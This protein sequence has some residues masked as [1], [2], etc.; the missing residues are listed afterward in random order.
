MNWKWLRRMAWLDTR[1]AFVSS[2]RHG[3]KLLD[4]GS[5]DGETLSHIAELRPDIALCACDVKGCP[6]KYPLGCHFERKNLE[7]DI[8]PWPN[9]SIDG[10]TCMHLVEHLASLDN[11]L[12]ECA[13]LL[14]PGARVYFETP[15]PKTLS[16]SSPPG[17]SA[18]S[19]TMN[20]FDDLTHIRPISVGGLA[21]L[22][23]K[24]GLGVVASG[25]SRN[26]LFATA[27]PWFILQ[28]P[29]RKRYTAKA[30][31]L[32]WSAFLIAEREA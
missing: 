24:K 32:G 27:Y 8:L 20:F 28:A 26:L 29:S 25:I 15:H 17:T 10:I 14:K 30:H 13:R 16:Y 4:L 22:C 3:G 7:T 23:R 31:W 18:G 21:T 6:E 1:A 11:L 19:F 9:A 2:L 12:A 5:S